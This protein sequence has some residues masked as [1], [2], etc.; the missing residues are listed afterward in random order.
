MNTARAE[1]SHPIAQLGPTIALLPWG[2]GKGD[3]FVV[4]VRD[5]PCRPSDA[6]YSTHWELSCYLHI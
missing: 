1:G 3:I 4:I 2:N 5:N 6:P